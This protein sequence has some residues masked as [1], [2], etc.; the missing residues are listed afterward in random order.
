MT[1]PEGHICVRMI[2]IIKPPPHDQ[3]EAFLEPLH[4]A[5]DD[6]LDRIY[7]TMLYRTP[8]LHE[9]NIPGFLAVLDA[10]NLTRKASYIP[11]QYPP[12]DVAVDTKNHKVFVTHN[13]TPGRVS[14]INGTEVTF[15]DASSDDQPFFLPNIT[16]VVVEFKSSFIKDA[17]QLNNALGVAISPET[18]EENNQQ[19]RRVY[20]LCGH[21]AK[22][23]VLDIENPD[24]PL[25]PSEQ[26]ISIIPPPPSPLS[27][28]IDRIA[29]DRHNRVYVPALKIEPDPA[30][31]RLYVVSGNT[32][33]PV[34]L[35]DDAGILKISQ[36]RD[37]AVDPTNKQIY[38]AN[39]DADNSISVLTFDPDNPAALPALQT[40]IV[41]PGLAP[42]VRVDPVLNLVYVVTR[43]GE[44]LE[45]I[46][47]GMN[48][49]DGIT[50]QIF[51]LPADAPLPDPHARLWAWGLDV[52][53]KSHRVYIANARAR[54]I[55]VVEVTRG[56]SAPVW[57]LST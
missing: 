36:P 4:V 43:I 19:I 18:E 53:V 51:K 16:P 24:V 35:Q 6:K 57:C 2:A 54:T 28:R 13:T 50:T 55:S 31:P 56:P 11:L 29:V 48:V 39:F 47:A 45:G 34:S 5:V 8:D 38:V 26:T 15:N 21:Q 12:R 37:V 10:N 49:I 17:G 42:V 23:A 32:P 41:V 14:V 3:G 20:V 27:V 52:S 1:T 22:I 33:S 44:S 7:V 40:T 46:G 25:P 9:P 30:D